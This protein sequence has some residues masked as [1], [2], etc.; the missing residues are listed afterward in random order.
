MSELWREFRSHTAALLVKVVLLVF[1]FLGIYNILSFSQSTDRAIDTSFSQQSSYNLYSIYDT[2]I[3]AD[4][5]SAFCDSERNMETVCDF[6]N[7]LNANEDLSF[8]SSFDQPL[9]I[10]DF[11]GG[12]SFHYAY[13]T[14]M[15]DQDAYTDLSG[16]VVEDIKS[17][18]LNEQTFRFYN[19]SVDGGAEPDWDAVDYAGDTI[20]VLLGSDY[21][22]VYQ[23]G[24]EITGLYY[25][26][27][28]TFKVSG[29]LSD[30]T[31]IY[32]KDDPNYYLDSSIVVPYPAELSTSTGNDFGFMARLAFAMVNGDVAAPKS[33]ESQDVLGILNTIGAES[34]F[35]DFSLL[36][37]PEYL[38]QLSFMRTLI[39][40]NSVLVCAAQALVVAATAIV[41]F[42]IDRA[43]AAYRRDK[44]HI[45][46]IAGDDREKALARLGVSMA[47]PDLIA[48][49]LGLGIA[50]CLPNDSAMAAI[51]AGAIFLVLIAVDF[52]VQRLLVAPARRESTR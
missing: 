35:Q 19:L 32:Y 30:G 22:D 25:F 52:A 43:L 28:T 20:P 3:D 26:K 48:L 38:V 23:V 42:F 10:V 36:N 11:Q 33:L 4:A 34:G 40:D 15:T 18:Q 27:E 17:L 39:A 14:E 45:W 49:A 13:G 50:A 9:S 21:R 24:D 31:S 41:V 44:A 1:A 6:Y 5:F 37:M 16:L 51:E 46:R 7:R 2:L 8:I 29:F 47:V 12:A